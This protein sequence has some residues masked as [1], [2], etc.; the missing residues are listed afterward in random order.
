MSRTLSL[1][2]LI[3]INVRGVF[4][5]ATP[6]KKSQAKETADDLHNQPE[7]HGD[8]VVIFDHDNRLLLPSFDV[9]AHHRRMRARRFTRK[10]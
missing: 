10:S 7:R 3:S 6:P 2:T 4:C 8:I 5:R 1:K 9:E